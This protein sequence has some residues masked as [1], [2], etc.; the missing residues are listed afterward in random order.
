MFDLEL[1]GEQ[2]IMRFGKK[3]N[4]KGHTGVFGRLTVNTNAAQNKP[5]TTTPPLVELSAP[6]TG[7]VSAQLEEAFKG[8]STQE[9]KA[10]LDKARKVAPSAPWSAVNDQSQQVI[11]K[12]KNLRKHCDRNT[13]KPMESA[14]K[15][16][17]HIEMQKYERSTK[18]AKNLREKEMTEYQAMGRVPFATQPDGMFKNYGAT[19]VKLRPHSNVLGV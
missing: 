16:L 10:L 1:D 7:V 5:T 12:K 11:D 8:L 14:D 4:L 9:R 6:V 13:G 19:A 2:Q 17:D 3:K 18:M 15:F